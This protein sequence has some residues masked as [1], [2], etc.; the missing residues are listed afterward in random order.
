MIIAIEFDAYN[1]Y[2]FCLRSTKAKWK[3]NPEV[4]AAVES[5]VRALPGC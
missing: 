5:A 1:G 2:E 3:Q 4:D